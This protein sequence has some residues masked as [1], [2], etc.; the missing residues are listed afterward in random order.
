MT[1]SNTIGTHAR[2]RF[3]NLLGLGLL[4]L[5]V[6]SPIGSQA[7]LRLL[8]PKVATGKSQTT[9]PYFDTDSESL[10]ANGSTT[11]PP[12]A[13]QLQTTTT[14]TSM[15]VAAVLGS[16]NTKNGSM[17]LW[18]NVKIPYQ[19]SLEETTDGWAS[20]N[21]ST[22]YS[23]LTGIP[24]AGIQIGAT[25]F[26]IE[27]SYMELNCGSTI[28][29]ST[30]VD[31]QPF[32]YD[33]LTNTT[34]SLSNGTYH[35]SNV[36]STILASDLST[37]TW[38]LGMDTFISPEFN[39]SLST[40]SSAKACEPGDNSYI[41]SPCYLR[42]LSDSQATSGT[43]LFQSLDVSSDPSPSPSIQAAFCQVQ[44]TYVESNITCTQSANTQP[45]CHVVTQ[46]NSERHRAPSAITPLSFPEIFD[47]ISLGLPRSFGVTQAGSKSDPSV[48]YLNSTSTTDIAQADGPAVLTNLPADVFSARLGQLLNTYY[49]LSQ[50]NTLMSEGSSS[51][52]PDKISTTATFTASEEV[53]SVSWA[54]FALLFI[55]TMLMLLAAVAGVICDCVN[56][57]P[58]IL[59]YTSS[60]IRDSKYVSL[61]SIDGP[62][63]D[64]MALTR[65]NRDFPL[66]MGS[67][68]EG[69]LVRSSVLRRDDSVRMGDPRDIVG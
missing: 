63:L 39:R 42:D 57:N 50:T 29:M 14:F 44:Q 17:D 67:V 43:L 6:M 27:S 7:F 19:S 28:G 18:G 22:I 66:K 10:L 13:A 2:L 45:D 56:L 48:F 8:S 35:G 51:S 68:S 62:S 46:R 52:F 69:G 25:D 4:T 23:A 21:D 12:D 53:Y 33:S 16:S 64:G 61:P 1:F 60:I 15:Y 41:A 26:S 30:F 36:S 58:E 5:W 55:A 65:K 3:F 24:I 49:S 54:W 34:Y 38:S 32:E 59:G 20:P 11:S 31:L 9:M 40:S 47:A 37:A